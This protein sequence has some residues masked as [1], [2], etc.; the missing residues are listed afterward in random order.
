M[1]AFN[2][3]EKRRGGNAASSHDVP[4]WYFSGYPDDDS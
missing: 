3:F 1:S 4:D 2:S